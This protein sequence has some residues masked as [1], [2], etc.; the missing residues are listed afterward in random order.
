[1]EDNLKAKAE[2]NLK[3]LMWIKIL[4]NTIFW[5][6]LW[7]LYYLK[8]TDYAGI[9][10]IESTGFIL[11]LMLEVPAGALSDRFGHK[12]NL[13][14]FTVLNLVGLVCF[15]IA[16][17]VLSLL[18]SV[19]IWRGA[20]SFYSGSFEALLHESLIKLEKG[21]QYQ[22]FVSRI[23][24]LALTTMA[25]SALI[26]GLLWKYNFR[27][28]FWTAIPFAIIAVVLSFKLTNFQEENTKGES[29]IASL[30]DGSKYIFKPNL[31]VVLISL[32][33]VIILRDLFEQIFDASLRVSAGM[34][35]IQLSLVSFTSVL[36]PALAALQYSKMKNTHKNVDRNIKVLSL[37]SLALSLPA[38]FVNK[39]MTASSVTLRAVPGLLLNNT[40]IE[41]INKEVPSRHRSTAISSYAFITALPY[42]ILALP[43]GKG[44]DKFG[45]N[46]VAFGLTLVSIAV[47]LSLTVVFRFKRKG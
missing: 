29:L 43:I 44:I 27:L 17:S 8:F 21:S 32:F 35:T 12:N 16:S 18:L 2:L 25:F 5:L 37:S 38:F 41:K 36:L 39:I 42:A 20:Y 47:Y 26:G 30:K 24:G 4:V 15:S 19:I 6:G 22:K 40:N 34:S 3:L 7:V 46:K 14:I 23:H 45:A 1:M 11:G 10:L 28:I 33:G 13:A 9:G 31:R